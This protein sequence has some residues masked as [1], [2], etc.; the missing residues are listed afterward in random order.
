MPAE[1]LPGVEAASPTSSGLVAAPS[2]SPLPRRALL[3]AALLLPAS[4]APQLPASARVVE[5]DAFRRF[6]IDVPDDWVV[7]AGTAT[8]ALE[9]RRVLVFH[10]PGDLETNV[11]VVET[12]TNADLTTLSSLG[13]PYEFG[14][15][16]VVS[17]DRRAAKKNPQVA[18]LLDTG[19]VGDA[20]TVAYRIARP[21]DGIDRSL[22]S[23]VAMR[24]DADGYI[25]RLFTVTGQRRTVDEA[26]DAA[27]RKVVDSFRL[28]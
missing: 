7:A 8:G 2:P 21:D 9:T 15:R 19:R 5:D 3:A 25:N 20:Y 18:T 22:Y 28:L 4:A 10:P 13:S 1:L 6:A 12:R 26:S 24:K 16:L 11:N 27:V 23:L 14:F 17:Q